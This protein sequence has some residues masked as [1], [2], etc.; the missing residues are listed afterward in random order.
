MKTLHTRALALLVCGLL[1]ATH[2]YGQYF[3][4]R[5]NYYN[6]NTLIL[7]FTFTNY[8]FYFPLAIAQVGGFL[9]G[10]IAKDGTEI[11]TPIFYDIPNKEY[12]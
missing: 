7:N 8:T 12:R 5:I 10:R 9:L 2:S 4:K 11:S 1:C 3:S 6:L